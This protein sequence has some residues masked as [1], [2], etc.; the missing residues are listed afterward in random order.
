MD[1]VISANRLHKIKFDR[2]REKL[3]LALFGLLNTLNK[4][5]IRSIHSKLFYYLV[6]FD[7]LCPSATYGGYGYINCDS[8]IL[9]SK[10]KRANDA[11]TRLKLVHI[12]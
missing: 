12:C 8:V 5:T 9:K 10:Q 3:I 7:V 1:R 6:C 11:P 2:L 4:F